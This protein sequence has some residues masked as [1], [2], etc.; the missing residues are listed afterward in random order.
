MRRRE[1]GKIWKKDDRVLVIQA[2]PDDTEYH[3]GGT[4]AKMVDEGL[5]W[6]MPP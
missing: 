1:T 3:V 2:H 4:I 6:I 5:S